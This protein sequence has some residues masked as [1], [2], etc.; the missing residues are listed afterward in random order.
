MRDMIKQ[1][2]WISDDFGSKLPV[3][4]VVEKCYLSLSK[5]KSKLDVYTNKKKQISETKK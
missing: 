4:L 2:P 1:V 5:S 3:V